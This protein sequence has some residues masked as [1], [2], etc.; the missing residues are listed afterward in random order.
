[1][2]E[3]PSSTRNSR[4][5]VRQWSNTNR[6]WLRLAVVL[7]SAGLTTAGLRWLAR[8][9]GYQP[10]DANL[11]LTLGL[12]ALL[13][14]TFWLIWHRTRPVATYTLEELVK[15]RERP[16]GRTDLPKDEP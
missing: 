8:F 2:A 10:N 7:L 14:L 3:D 1:M 5:P 13:A 15:D 16:P 6:L 9:Y 12:A 11:P 4:V